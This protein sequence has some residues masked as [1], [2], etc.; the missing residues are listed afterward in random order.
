[1]KE[2]ERLVVLGLLIAALF[3]NSSAAQAPDSPDPASTP[4]AAPAPASQPSP[5]QKAAASQVDEPAGWHFEWAEHPSLQF[6]K[7]TRI[8]FRLRLQ[9]HFRDSDAE[10]GDDGDR[11]L[12]RRRV[13][14]EGNVKGLVEFQVERELGDDD[15]WRDVFVNYRQFAAAEVQAGKFKQPFSLDENT[16]V[17]NLDFIYRSLAASQL[18]PGRARGVMVH[19]RV[20]DRIVRYE[21]GLF[22]HDGQNARSSHAEQVVGES[23]IAG[24]LTATPFRHHHA[25]LKDL[26]FGVA[27]TDSDVP[28]GFPG[29][30]GHSLLDAPFFTSQLWVNG[31]RQRTGLEARWR[32]GPASIKAEYIRVSTER[33]GESIE[34]TDL[35]PLVATGWYVSGTWA[36]TGEKKSKDLTEP[37]HPL[38]RGGWGAIEVAARAEA[39]TFGTV[40]GG[41]TASNS[42]RA[43]VI[44]GNSDHAATFGV[45]WYPVRHVKLQF[46][47]IHERFSDPT[48]G[49]APATPAFWSR[50]L[51]FQLDL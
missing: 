34:D 35:A 22:D 39:L 31:Q 50:V 10:I 49:P 21:I 37:R 19:G 4:A 14:V 27:F 13:G 38:F 47:V 41:E 32:P 26:Q 8:D 16:S 7:D 33:R 2:I 42:P 36:L 30:H 23:T 17:T 12:A 46:N 43:E 48:R 51:R 25:L 9:K 28:E 1:V 20:L 15:P 44:L 6:G 29:L 5:A 3:A 40:D 11:D 24:R 18:S 45:N